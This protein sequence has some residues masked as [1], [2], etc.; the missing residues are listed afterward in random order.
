MNKEE[1]E[2][3]ARETAKWIKIERDLSEFN[4]TLT[5]TLIETADAFYFAG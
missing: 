3:F 2:N 4:Q 1:L 5:K